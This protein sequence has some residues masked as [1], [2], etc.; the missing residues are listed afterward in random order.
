MRQMGLKLLGWTCIGLNILWYP[1]MVNV[2]RAVENHFNVAEED[3]RVGGS[4][5]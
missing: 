1:V 5:C 2:S 4:V 3:E